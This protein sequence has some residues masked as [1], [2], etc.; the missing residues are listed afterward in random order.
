MAAHHRPI[1][2]QTTSTGEAL[3]DLTF[4]NDYHHNETIPGSL[5]NLLCVV[6]PISVFAAF[7]ILL[8]PQGDTHAA[9]CAY[10]LTMGSKIF[11]V[12]C[13]KN[14][15]GYLRPSFY[16]MCQFNP[17][18]LLCDDE[19]TSARESFPSGHAATA[20]SSMTLLALF[21]LGKV[22]GGIKQRGLKAERRGDPHDEIWTPSLP[23]KV[24]AVASV[25]PVFLGMFIASSRVRDNWHHPADILCGGVI[26][27]ACAV[28]AHSLW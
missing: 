4:A 5:L 25:A 26:G 12:A 9:V 18:T 17:E 19:T 2:I 23:L 6:F 16:N 24:L 22:R 13:I 10:I 21:L 1:P 20:L 14:Y 11:V 7:G 8:G 3:I 28:F 15:A 27:A